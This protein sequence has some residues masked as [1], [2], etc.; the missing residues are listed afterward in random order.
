MDTHCLS[1]KGAQAPNPLPASV[2]SIMRDAFKGCKSLSSID[3]K[4]TKDGWNNINIYGG[5]GVSNVTIWGSDGY[6]TKT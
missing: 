6:I 2:T 4:G 5:I 1:E 3:Y